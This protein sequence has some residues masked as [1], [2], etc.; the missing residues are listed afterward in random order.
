[1]AADLLRVQADGGSRGNPGVAGCGSI[2]SDPAT[3]AVL[4]RIAWVVGKKASNNV[5]EYQ[6]LIN[7]LS[8][9]AELGARAVEVRM[10][11]KLVVEQ[12]SGRWKIKH[13]DMKKLAMEANRIAAGFDSVSYT[14]VPRKE[15]AEADELANKAMDAAKAGHAVGEIAAESTG[16]AGAGEQPAPEGAPSG[17]ERWRAPGGTT[18]RLILLRHGQTAYSAA[19]YYS[20]HANPALTETGRRQAAA[21]AELIRAR[22][23]IDAVVCSPL[24]RA[25]ETAQFCAD[26]LSL[27]V[28]VDEGLI[29]VD[30]GD[31]EGL[32]FTQAHERAGEVHTDWLADP[33][34]APPNGESLADLHKR[35][36]R[37]LDGVLEKYAGQTVLAVSHVNPIKSV[38]ANALGGDAHTFG[39]VFLD[40]AGVS[41]VEFTDGAGTVR[42]VNVTGGL[43][44]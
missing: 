26:A 2:V 15:N 17:P 7:G 32:T 41:V 11:S 6:G 36:S 34:I 27:E 4:R 30:F 8:A 44:R 29:E 42:A 38:L 12:M 25:R 14:W 18:T 10:D 9:A 19:G 28:D 33:T 20:G 23:G 37:W 21:A 39:H 43:P 5:A 24:E 40:L 31:F 13:P 3:G 22:G 35:V 1:M 16:G